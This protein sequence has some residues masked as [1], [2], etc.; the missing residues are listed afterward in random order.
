M[1]NDVAKK[2]IYMNKLAP[3]VMR[4]HL[5]LNQGRL[6]TSDDVVQEI[7]EYVEACEDGDQMMSGSVSAVGKGK[8][9]FDVKRSQFDKKEA[10]GKGKRQEQSERFEAWRQGQGRGLR[11]GRA[12]QRIQ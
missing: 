7:E 5:R 4:Q 12:P 3:E 8:G 6:M 9:A 11:E 10:E 2:S 1:L